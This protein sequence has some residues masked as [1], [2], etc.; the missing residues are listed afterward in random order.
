MRKV[1]NIK[2]C[3]TNPLPM[4]AILVKDQRGYA[5]NKYNSFSQ[6]DRVGKP[7]ACLL[8]RPHQN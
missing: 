7:Y 2:L 3:D 6:N 1:L 4:A 8:P 5:I